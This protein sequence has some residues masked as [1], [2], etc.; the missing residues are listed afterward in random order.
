MGSLGGRCSY[1]NA[2]NDRG[3]IVGWSLTSD[4]K[5]RAYLW[6]R[7]SMIQLQSHSQPAFAWG[8]NN[9]GQVVG[10]LLS[11][12]GYQAVMWDKGDLT[13]LPDLEYAEWGETTAT[14]INEKGQI[15]GF[16]CC[17]PFRAF[18]WEKGRAVD[19][20]TL[21]TPFAIAS[22]IN[23][24]GQIVGVST[25]P[26]GHYRP[27][28]WEDGSMKDLGTWRGYGH[29][30]DINNRGQVV[31]I[32]YAGREARAFL[33]ENGVMVDLGTVEGSNHS[34]AYAINENGIVVG[35]AEMTDGTHAVLWLP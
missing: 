25:E 30:F 12:H 32:D 8:I 16:S 33:W 17:S 1:A 28:I 18:L 7:E 2:I 11:T 35:S 24:R 21:G 29:A 5:S 22:G 34:A 13:V 9:R 27:F 15:V 4:R 10:R 23:N 3:Q 19:L 6:E 31:G 20:G 14:A 26:G